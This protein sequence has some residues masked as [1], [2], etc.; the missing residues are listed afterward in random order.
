MTHLIHQHTGRGKQVIGHAV[1]A[2]E[3]S[4]QLTAVHLDAHVL[5]RDAQ[6]CEGRG[7]SRQQLRLCLHAI[8][9]P[10]IHVPLVMLA[11]PPTSHALVAPALGKG[12]PLEREGQRILLCHDH[13]RQRRGHLWPQTQAPST[14]VL[15]VVQLLGDLFARLAD[16]Q[17]LALHD[18]RIVLLEAE[19]LGHTA[20]AIKQPLLPA[21]LLRIEVPRALG[22]LYVQLP[23]LPAATAVRVHLGHSRARP[24][25]TTATTASAVAQH[26]QHTPPCERERT[27]HSCTSQ[28]QNHLHKPD[29]TQHRCDLNTH[30]A[31]TM[32]HS[33]LGKEQKHSNVCHNSLTHCATPFTNE[34]GNIEQGRRP[35]DSP[36]VIS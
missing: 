8:H 1:G 35:D 9:A 4:E 28:T 10:D 11:P 13:A 2:H 32:R 15:E 31:P 22:R 6:V 12:E 19:A 20:P 3:V 21:H 5:R 27:N 30:G 33:D 34:F 14:F 17:A 24:P 23:L 25:T 29:H 26:T 18:G 36:G 7:D 16:V